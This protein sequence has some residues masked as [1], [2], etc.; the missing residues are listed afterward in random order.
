MKKY[1]T[2]KEVS[3]M[4]R[5]AI[6][7]I[8]AFIREKKIPSYKVGGKRLFDQDEIEAWMKKHREGGE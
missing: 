5:M 8:Y 4:L 1:L 2:M 7:T 6:P 3:E